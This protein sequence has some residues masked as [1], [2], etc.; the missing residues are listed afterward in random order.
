M[1]AR[2]IDGKAVAATILEEIGSL[3]RSLRDA[4]VTPG[5][6]AVLVGDDPASATYVAGKE[7]D[8]HAV[9]MASFVHRLP[10]STSQDE[11]MDLVRDLHDDPALEGRF[12]SCCP[13]RR[14]MPM[15]R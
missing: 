7:K 11:L 13:T 3:V 2:I 12:R 8:A 9:G 14:P 1:P 10:A 15:P 6:A 4:G 5:L